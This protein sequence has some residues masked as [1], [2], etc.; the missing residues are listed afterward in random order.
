MPWRETTLTDRLING[1]SRNKGMDPERSSSS[2]LDI[3]LFSQLKKNVLLKQTLRFGGLSL[4]G[5]ILSIFFYVFASRKLGPEG[6]GELGLLM[7]LI[8]TLLIVL[9]SIYLIIN[10]FIRQYA[11]RGQTENIKFLIKMSFFD[12]FMLGMAAFFICI[13]LSEVVAEFFRLAHPSTVIFFGA[14]VWVSFLTPVLDGIF[15]GME[16]FNYAGFFKFSES[17]F[18]LILAAVFLA[19]VADVSAALCA[20]AIGTLLSILACLKPLY[21]FKNTNAY[22][23]YLSEFYG[24][25]L[26]IIA[27]SL[28]IALLLN[29]D[30]ILVK[31][32]FLPAEAGF[33]SAASII[34][35]LPFL[36]SVVIGG[37][38]FTNV[39]ERHS[40]GKPTALF[41]KKSLL[42]LGAICALIFAS[43]L[44]FG[45]AISAALFGPAYRVGS[46]LVGYSLAFMFF[47]FVNIFVLYSFARKEYGVVAILIV[48]LVIQ[49]ALLLLFHQTL[50][51]VA[52]IL[53]I[54]MGCLLVATL[55]YERKE[56][57]YF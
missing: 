33:F 36:L 35:K 19:F 56:F 30:D 8:S 6:Y 54:V 1:F 16:S 32:Y 43:V 9:S 40:N 3:P 15:K 46:F 48:A 28:A 51:Q 50:S 26:P 52:V 18:R 21:R 44:L 41:L 45:P 5:A 38:M 53:G 55:A 13:L 25:S 17:G 39:S 14:L 42:L 7:A 11:R 20:L 37:V 31:H 24:Y 49:F 22:K 12:S 29:L 23:I 10:R 27:G 4:L 34:A 57:F 47:S 2:L